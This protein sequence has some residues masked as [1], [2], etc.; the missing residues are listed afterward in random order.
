MLGEAKSLD[1]LKKLVAMVEADQA[2][3]TMLG[4]SSGLTRFANS[5]IH[6]NVFERDSVIYLRAAIGKKIGV[7]SSNVM[8]QDA[9][10]GLARRVADIARSQVDNPDFESFA[11]SPRAPKVDAFYP[12]TANCEALRRAANVKV[13]IDAAA[14]LNLLAAGSHYTSARELAFANSLG[15]EQYHAFTSAYMSTV[16]MSPTSSGYADLS[17]LDISRFDPKKVADQAVKIC[18]DSQD[19]KELPEGRYD[20]VITGR[21]LSELMG[22]LAYVGF[23]VDTYQDGR[24]FM[25]GRIGEKV[26]GGNISMWD[27]GLDKAGAPLPFDFE[28]VPRKRVDLIKKGV[29]GDVCYGT[30][31]ASKDKKSSTGHALLPGDEVSAMPL[32]IFVSTGKNTWEEMVASLDKGLVVTRFHY[33]NGLLDTRR[34]LFTGMTRDGTFYVE[35]GKVKYPVKNLRFTHSMLDAFSNV[36]MASK[37]AKLFLSDWFGG[38]VLPALKIKGFNF[39]GKTEF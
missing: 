17:A 9:M 26:M 16:V 10:K 29:I 28:G 13:V 20:V 32:N 39:S 21:A 35:G 30:I 12:E 27:D 25:S 6:Q 15:T 38:S 34:A 14:K 5:T 22:W 8:D 11:K 18:A 1:A 24:S 3:A 23:S 2:E 36:E 19:P 33:V 7:A 4:I 37:D 31:T